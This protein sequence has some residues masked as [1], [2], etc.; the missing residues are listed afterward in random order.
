MGCKINSPPPKEKKKSW[1]AADKYT[2]IK[3]KD[4]VRWNDED[5]EGIFGLSLGERIA[6]PTQYNISPA[7]GLYNLV[8]LGCCM[9]VSP[10]YSE[11][12]TG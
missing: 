12:P 8:R 5:E 3:S 9:G 1:K 4:P 7:V 2:G 6:F 10:Q 11:V